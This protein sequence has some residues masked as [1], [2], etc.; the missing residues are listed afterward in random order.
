[1][2]K[3]YANKFIKIELFNF[4][5]IGTHKALFQTQVDFPVKSPLILIYCVAFK[6][7]PLIC[8]SVA[9]VF[10]QKNLQFLLEINLKIIFYFFWKQILLYYNIETNSSAINLVLHF[11][12]V[13]I[14]ILANLVFIW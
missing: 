2:D 7:Y 4:V 5:L 6:R 11:F 8:E 9:L 3:P 13:Y 12:T 14:P 10:F 1:V